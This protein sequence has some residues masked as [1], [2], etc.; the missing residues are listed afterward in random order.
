LRLSYVATEHPL[1]TEVTPEGLVV[2]T[3]S[4]HE[5]RA[6]LD[7]VAIAPDFS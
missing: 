2:W 7:G 6:E 5:P 1:V 4:C 3:H